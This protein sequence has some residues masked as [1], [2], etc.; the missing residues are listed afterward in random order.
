MQNL[1]ILGPTIYTY[2]RSVLTA[3]FKSSELTYFQTLLSNA[4]EKHHVLCLLS[5]EEDSLALPHKQKG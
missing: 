4:G 5:N 2:Y 1:R 3:T